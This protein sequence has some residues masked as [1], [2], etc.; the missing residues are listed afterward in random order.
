VDST[1]GKVAARSFA[2]DGGLPSVRSRSAHAPRPGLASGR[3]RLTI[4]GRSTTATGQTPTILP[5]QKDAGIDKSDLTKKSPCKAQE[6]FANSPPPSRA[7]QA[8]HH[9]GSR[10][11]PSQPLRAGL[12][13]APRWRHKARI[14]AALR[15]RTQSRRGPVGAL[16][17]ARDA[18]LPREG[19]RRAYRLRARQAQA[20]PPPR[21]SR[22]SLLEAIR[23]ALL[24][25]LCLS[26]INR[27]NSGGRDDGSP[28]H[29][30]SGGAG[31][32]TVRKS[33]I[34][35]TCAGHGAIRSSGQAPPPSLEQDKG[36][37][38][39]D[40]RRALRMYDPLAPSIVPK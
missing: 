6:A 10:A 4:A 11:H 28:R 1:E 5:R 23:I 39:K 26:N 22:R 15:A 38:R 3:R 40:H 21:N 18:Q 13:R 7:P 35:A 9:L 33:L 25:L 24:T 37:C 2:P 19:L 17:T 16:E 14:P 32:N 12:R 27:S 36:F 20:H 29:G 30:D 31:S 8:P 34:F